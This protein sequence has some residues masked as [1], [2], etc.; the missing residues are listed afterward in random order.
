MNI[1]ICKPTYVLT[2]N[3]RIDSR[4][5]HNFCKLLA[6]WK[7]HFVLTLRF[8]EL[9]AYIVNYIFQICSINYTFLAFSL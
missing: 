9:Q 3:L 2:V 5:G 4:K 8:K 7:Q 1:D 6:L